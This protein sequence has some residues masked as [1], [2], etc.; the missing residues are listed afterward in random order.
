MFLG[1][2]HPQNP[3]APS[4]RDI[5]R[6]P[7]GRIG[8]PEGFTTNQRPDSSRFWHT[9]GKPNHRQAPL[10]QVRPLCQ[11]RFPQPVRKP[12]FVEIPEQRI[13]RTIEVFI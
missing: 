6:R 9:Q 4:E 13:G 7:S 2:A 8:N 1:T 3:V 12:L 5:T 10:L 11:D